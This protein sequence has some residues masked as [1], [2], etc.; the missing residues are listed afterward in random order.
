MTIV[1]HQSTARSSVRLVVPLSFTSRRRYVFDFR[2]RGDSFRLVTLGAGAGGPPWLDLDL[3]LNI[4][5]TDRWER[6][7]VDFVPSVDADGQLFFH[8]GAYDP[9]VE[10]ADMAI[11]SL[12]A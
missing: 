3:G 7:E 1:K 2:A 6:F 12:P 5:L 9:A 8:V 11:T 4:T 10:F